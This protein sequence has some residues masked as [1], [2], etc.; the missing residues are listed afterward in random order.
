MKRREKHFGRG[1]LEFIEE[2]VHLV[3]ST[4]PTAMAAYLIGTLPFILGLL[5]FWAEM[6]RSAFA[7][8]YLQAGSLG[9]AGLFVWMKFWQGVFM[10][11]LLA[12]LCGEPAPRWTTRRALRSTVFQAAVQPW[13]LVLLPIASVAIVPFPWFYGFFQNVSL[14]GDGDENTTAGKTLRSAWKQASAWPGQSATL[15]LVLSLF[16]LFVFI[17]ILY[18]VLLPAWALKTFLG[19]ETVFSRGGFSTMNTTFLSVGLAVTYLCVD[20]LLKAVYTL[21]CFYGL[22]R[23]TGQDLLAELKQ[24]LI[25]RRTAALL[26]V[27]LLIGI[28][29]LPTVT[30]AQNTQNTPSAKPAPKTATTPDELDRSI[31]RT[32]R[33]KEYTWRMPR[34]Q[35]RPQETEQGWLGKKWNEFWE[36]WRKQ[37][38]REEKKK[39]KEAFEDREASSG[40]GWAGVLKWVAYVLLGAVAV[41][42]GVLLYKAWRNSKRKKDQPVEAATASATADLSD[43]NTTADDLPEEGWLELARK[44]LAGGD[45]RKALR[46]MYLASLA[47]LADHGM[48]TIARF[49]SNFEYHRELQRRGH[50]IPHVIVA[51]GQ[52][53]GFFE[54]SWYGMH[55]ITDAT[56]ETFLS[57]QER[58]R[59]FDRA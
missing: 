50:S 28:F 16:S 9:L 6:S 29:A 4:P 42:L 20:P 22:S 21:R 57:N 43:E 8:Y 49:K 19:V 59:H 2:A 45:R 5:F 47:G 35:V 48:I 31:R 18:A 55:E 40:F 52:N 41:A 14:L 7:K 3:R 34:E 46:A 15:L 30:Q 33:R 11:H 10:R 23:T 37:R 12:R 58:I 27:V 38:E 54:D 24:F 25:E 26:A 51:F 56:V 39:Q 44:M 32:I 1:A 53:V 36:W 13:G 17:N